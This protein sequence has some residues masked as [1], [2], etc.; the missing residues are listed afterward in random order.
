MLTI[1]FKSGFELNQWACFIFGLCQAFVPSVKQGRCSGSHFSALGRLPLLWTQL[2]PR[3]RL[4]P[5]WKAPITFFSP[6][7]V[8]TGS[9]SSQGAIQASWITLSV[10]LVSTSAVCPFSC[11]KAVL[12]WLRNVKNHSF[13]ECVASAKPLLCCTSWECTQGQQQ[14]F[15]STINYWNLWEEGRAGSQWS[16]LSCWC[17]L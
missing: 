15:C 1:N 4:T 14:E 5:F 7:S 9:L 3:H 8:R 2:I 17:W 13:R 11:T 16:A 10:C 6:E 12:L